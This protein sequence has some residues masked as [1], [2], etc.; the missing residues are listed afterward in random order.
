MVSQASIS[1]E[2][3]VII[4]VG[5]KHLSSSEKIKWLPLLPLGL[6]SFLSP[7]PEAKGRKDV[8]H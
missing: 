3:Q 7:D 8:E 4:S 2:S 6:L 1:V 5:R